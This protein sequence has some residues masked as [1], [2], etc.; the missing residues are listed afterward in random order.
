MPPRK[1][2]RVSVRSGAQVDGTVVTFG[3]QAKPAQPTGPARQTQPDRPG[4]L[5]LPSDNND[6]DD[7]P[8]PEADPP[9]TESGET[10]EQK[11]DVLVGTSAE[12][13]ADNLVFFLEWMHN[14][15]TLPASSGEYFVFDSSQQYSPRSAFTALK[16]LA[17]HLKKKVKGDPSILR[18]MRVNMSPNLRLTVE[19]I[20]NFIFNADLALQRGAIGQDEEF[21]Q[22]ASATGKRYEINLAVYKKNPDEDRLAGNTI[23]YPLENL[24]EEFGVIYIEG[25]KWRVVTTETYSLQDDPDR[26]QGIP[27]WEEDLIEN[28]RNMIDIKT[29][30]DQILDAEKRIQVAGSIDVDDIDKK[31][32]L[33]PPFYPKLSTLELQTLMNWQS[34]VQA[35]RKNM[36]KDSLYQF[37]VSVAGRLNLGPNGVSKLLSNKNQIPG[38][39]AMVNVPSSAEQSSLLT[40]ERDQLLRLKYE[41]EY[42]LNQQRMTDVRLEQIRLNA[43]D[44]SGVFKRDGSDETK[45]EWVRNISQFVNKNQANKTEF[46]LEGA[47]IAN[48]YNT[49]LSLDSRRL[50]EAK[51]VI[52]D[53]IRGVVTEKSR[54]RMFHALEWLQKIEILERAEMTPV[55]KA[56]IDEAMSKVASECCNLSS[57]TDFQAF[58]ETE[59]SVATSYF[60]RL[61]QLII[62]GF[63]NEH[64]KKNYLDKRV[65]QINVSLGRHLRAMDEELTVVN[66]KVER[67][68]FRGN[69]MSEFNP[70]LY[71]FS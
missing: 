56:G 1:V 31:A 59:D 36:V 7:E 70:A 42:A 10:N 28:P 58:I 46:P 15:Q 51:N 50:T 4:W 69:T 65:G 16:A 30:F 23:E 2:Q 14:V 53:M 35:V 11:E 5:T 41:I 8:M 13:K 57:V 40:S 27:N 43:Y 37:A 26:K 54:E 29:I 60:A 3:E 19:I 24:E 44:D 63:E 9:S 49:P 32:S 39:S 55:F 67:K 45:R 62:A 38:F 12:A 64:P 34:A 20:N 61:V 48:R 52:D 68:A 66:G 21:K 33:E 17:Y 6:D 71:A 25:Y 18:N 47:P 22:Y